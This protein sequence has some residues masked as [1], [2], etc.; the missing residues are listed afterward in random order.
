MEPVL[1]HPGGLVGRAGRRPR[2]A[3]QRRGGATQDDLSRLVA[4]VGFRAQAASTRRAHVM[5]PCVSLWTAV[6]LYL[7]TALISVTARASVPSPLQSLVSHTHVL[8]GTL[9]CD[10]G[11]AIQPGSSDQCTQCPPGTYKDVKG[12]A[13]CSLCPYAK[14]SNATGATSVSACTSCPRWHFADKGSRQET[15]CVAP[16]PA[17]R[18]LRRRVTETCKTT[19]QDCVDDVECGSARGRGTCRDGLCECRHQFRGR[20][21][22]FCQEGFDGENCTEACSLHGCSGHGRCRISSICEC[23]KGYVATNNY[24]CAACPAGTFANRTGSTQCLECP[25]HSHSPLAGT[26]V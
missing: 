8:S 15:D 21:C 25:R 12:T 23:D 17:G 9:L 5:T 13:A 22:S 10:P 6:C 7:S 14:F 18:V 11:Y 24:T 4:S 19:R 3:G 26:H 2:L 16:G 1:L 20:R